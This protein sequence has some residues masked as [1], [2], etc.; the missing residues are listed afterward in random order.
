MVN[1]GS[2]ATPSRIQP[3]VAVRGGW[4]AERQAPRTFANR[5]YIGKP[6]EIAQEI[7]RNEE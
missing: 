2:P 4:R 7:K 1:I 6:Q 3:F 5:K